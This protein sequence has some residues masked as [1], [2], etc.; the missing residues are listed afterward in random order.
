M[1]L[2]DCTLALVVSVLLYS[3]VILAKPT[4]SVSDPKVEVFKQKLLTSL[5]Y[6]EAPVVRN[7]NSSIHEQR[8]MIRKYKEHIKGRM[9][10]EE[11]RYPETANI[12]KPKDSFEIQPDYEQSTA[13]NLFLSYD[14]QEKQPEDPHMETIISRAHVKIDLKESNNLTAQIKVHSDNADEFSNLLTNEFVFSNI[15]TNANVVYL[16]ITSLLRTWLESPTENFGITISFTANISQVLK[17][18]SK[19]SS[20]KAFRLDFENGMEPVLEVFSYRKMILGR[21]KRQASTA[22]SRRDC[23]KGDGENRCCRFRTYI[24]FADIGWDNWIIRP[25]GYEA[26]Y[27]DGECPHRFKMANTFAG[28]KSLLHMKNPSTFSPPCCV[29]SKLS[30]FTILHKEE[31]GKYAFM[32]LDDMVVEDCKCA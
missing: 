6:K 5:G 28:I 32:D 1:S 17:I 29:P 13:A 15:P 2:A 7:I 11:E 30:P 20:G 23:V 22:T 16:D 21:E 24:S 3:S 8:A 31:S 12:Y 26:Y 27:C 25:S 18:N 4:R 14:I 10:I 9:N 19:K